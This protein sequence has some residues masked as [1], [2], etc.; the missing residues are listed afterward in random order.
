MQVIVGSLCMIKEKTDEHSNKILTCPS[1]HEIQ[2]IALWGTAHL[3]SESTLNVT[4]KYH[5]KEAAK[6]MNT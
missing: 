2:K 4:G 3:L 1:R 5:P 6:N